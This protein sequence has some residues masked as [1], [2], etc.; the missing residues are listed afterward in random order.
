MTFR[1]V[2]SA[3]CF[4]TDLF[5]IR[6]YFNRCKKIWLKSVA[7]FIDSWKGY[8]EAS[9]VEAVSN[10]SWGES[11][12]HGLFRKFRGHFAFVIISETFA[13]DSLGDSDEEEWLRF[14]LWA[15]YPRLWTVSIAHLESA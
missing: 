12:C 2:C 11:V 6:E 8:G 1:K 13:R 4:G 5:K 3:L 9:G 10:A 14:Y 15:G 7:T